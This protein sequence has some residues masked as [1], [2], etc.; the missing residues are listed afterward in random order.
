MQHLLDTTPPMHETQPAATAESADLIEP[1]AAAEPVLA[2][3]ET[4]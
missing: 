1:A 4:L 2:E 3:A